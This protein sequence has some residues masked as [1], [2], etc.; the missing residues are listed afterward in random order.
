[1]DNLEKLLRAARP[2]VP[3]LPTDFEQMVMTRIV[4][5]GV[6]FRSADTNVLLQ[7]VRIAIGL[8]ML[9]VSLVLFNYNS[10]ELSSN[11]SLELLYF[12]TR[13]F[14]DFLGYLPW[15][16]IISSMA[17]TGLSVWLIGKSRILKRGI[18]LIAVVSYLVTGIGG[19]ALAATGINNTIEAGI[20][21]H[22]QSLPW[23]NLFQNRRA[24][25]FIHHP[26][27][28]MGK[29][30]E[31]ENGV[32]VVVTPHGDKIRI[33]LPEAMLVKAG[34]V[35]RMS[36]EGNDTLFSAEQVDVCNPNRVGRYFSHLQH[37][38]QMMRSCCGNQGMMN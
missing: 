19:A 31:V 10:Y 23:L 33:Q 16:L 32:A 7:K 25:E 11:G 5:Q 21:R 15:D 4:N 13:Y 12:G 35:L 14:F 36:G 37:H 3:D 28:K 34:Q 18:A 22:E 2:S 30:E 20:S 9:A 29:V 6:K 26:N 17:L 8:V 27:F 24:H 1:M 38:Q